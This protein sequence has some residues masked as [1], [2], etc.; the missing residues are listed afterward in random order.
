L[1]SKSLASET[2]EATADAVSL[3]DASSTSRPHL[4]SRFYESVSDVIY[5][6]RIS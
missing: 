4:W 1:G 2:L 3:I 5:R 6:C